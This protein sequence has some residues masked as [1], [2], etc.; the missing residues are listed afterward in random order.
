MMEHFLECGNGMFSMILCEVTFAN[1]QFLHA[2][3]QQGVYCKK[4]V[5]VYW[6]ST[7]FEKSGKYTE[8]R[9]EGIRRITQ[10]SIDKGFLGCL[11]KTMNLRVH[12]FSAQLISIS[13]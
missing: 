6:K 7:D 1:F 11:N 12:N 2:Q 8:F 3:C 5:K 10:N 4:E 13:L 9:E